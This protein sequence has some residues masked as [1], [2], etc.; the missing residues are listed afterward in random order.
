MCGEVVEALRR[1]SL[2]GDADNDDS[3]G[4]TGEGRGGRGGGEESLHRSDAESLTLEA[5]SRGMQYRPDLTSA[6]L[7]AVRSTPPSHHP[8]SDVWLLLCAASAPHHRTKVLTLLRSKSVSGAF[9]EELLRDA[10]VGQGRSIRHLFEASALEMADGLVRS[11]ESSARILG[12]E[13]YCI[14]Y[15]E[16]P[17]PARRQEVVGGLVTHAGAGG[18][19]GGG[20]MGGGGE[21]ESGGNTEVD[22]AMTVLCRI[23]GGGPSGEVGLRP[24]LPFLSSLLDHIRSLAL[25][26]ARRLF[27]VLFSVGCDDEED[28]N[29]NDDV[30][31][32]VGGSAGMGGGCDDVHIVIRKYLSL[33]Q[34]G[35]K[36]IV[37]YSHSS[38]WG[39]LTLRS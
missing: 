29:N 18:G 33:P 5:I 26:Q 38:L 30:P 32:P 13:L 1:M 37:S 23:A 10:L 19:G 36:C 17:D 24:F 25:G 16:F 27:L 21:G 35:L 39:I 8:P 4:A 34:P 14:L 31:P 3:G 20:G 12:G 15:R 6:F 11:P 2:G 7:A 22:A 28:D 9:T